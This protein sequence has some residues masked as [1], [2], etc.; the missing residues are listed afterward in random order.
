MRAEAFQKLSAKD[1]LGD[2]PFNVDEIALWCARSAASAGNSRLS[3][4]GDKKP[5]AQ[6]ANKGTLSFLRALADLRHAT[7]PQSASGLPH[8]LN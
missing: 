4:N 3:R 8:R 7:Y 1:Q 6:N 5:H 2:A